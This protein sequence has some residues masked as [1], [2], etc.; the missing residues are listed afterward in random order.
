MVDCSNSNAEMPCEVS[1][2]AVRQVALVPNLT[3]VRV[4]GIITAIRIND[5]GNASHLVIQDPA[6]GD[7]AGLWVY[8]NDTEVENLPGFIEG[9]QVS[10]T[11]TI[12][13]FFGQRQL[14]TII[15][16]TMSADNIVINPIIVDADQ[17]AT[18]GP[19][20]PFYEGMLVTVE[21]V[22]VTD[23]NPVK[24]PGDTDPINEFVV[25]NTLRIDDFLT[26]LPEVSVG[27]SFTSITGVLRLGNGNYKIIPRRENELVP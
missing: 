14:N 21:N 19:L 22:D 4:S 13:D 10:I 2:Q 17:I 5:D 25:D 1:I 15:D 12:D 11:A 9:Y 27:D 6:G 24:G 7:Y 20:A 26:D 3:V 8:L 18:D 16:V 23:A